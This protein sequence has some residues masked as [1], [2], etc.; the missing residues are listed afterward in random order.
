[1]QEKAPWSYD[2]K[3][4]EELRVALRS[5]LKAILALRV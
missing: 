5:I 3:K 2:D 1:M 4:A